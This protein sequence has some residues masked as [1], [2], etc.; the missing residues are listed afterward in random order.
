MSDDSLHILIV[1]DDGP[2]RA[3]TCQA[4]LL[5]RMS[6]AIDEAETAEDA[7]RALLS[8]DYDCALLE[9]QLPDGTGLD[10]MAQLQSEGIETPVVILSRH[11]DAMVAVELMKAGAADYQSKT[12]ITPEGLERAVKTAVRVRRAEQQAQT[13]DIARR[14]SE[15]QFRRVAES[16]I[17]GI[18]FWD[19]S[20]TVTDANDAFL[21]MVGYTRADL[22][23]GVIDWIALT[24]PEWQAQDRE[25]V[26]ELEA[27]GLCAPFEK[28]YI[29]KDGERVAVL[30]TTSMLEGS[31]DRG[32]AFVVDVTERRRT[33]KAQQFLAEA[34][35]ILSSSLNYAETLTNVASLAVPHLADWCVIDLRDNG[36]RV[37]Q[38][39]VAHVDPV[40]VE[41]LREMERRFPVDPQGG[42]GVP[43]V[44][45]T[46]RSLWVP[47]IT[48]DDLASVAQSEEHLESLRGYGLLSYMCVPLTA[49]GR[50]LGAITFLTSDSGR[51]YT[52]ADLALAEELA[53]R[54][55]LAVDNA[56]LF[57]E[58]Q[59]RAEREAVVNAIGQTLRGSL[60]ADEILE[61][62]TQEVGRLLK[63]SRCGWYWINAA[64]DALEVAPQQYV[65]GDV[66]S[67][68]GTFPLSLWEPH[69]LLHWQS[70]EA[71]ISND[72]EH[73]AHLAAYR[74]SFLDPLRI[75]AFVACPVF[76]RGVWKGLFMIQ[77]TDAPRVWTEDEVTLLRQVADMLAPTLENA[78]LYAREH[79]VADLLQAA[80]LSNV[81]THLNGLD[82]GTVYRPGLDESKVGGDFYDAF[83]TSDGRVGLVLG[84]VS[85]K[86]LSAAVLTATAKF[87][88]RAFA[89]EVAAPGLVLTRLNH[90][91]QSEMAGLGDHFVTLFYAVFDPAG[92]HL[93][94]ASAGHE[95]QIIKR[96]AG[97][98]SLLP[99]TGPILGIAEHR[100]EQH[101]ETLAPGDTLILYTDGLTEARSASTRELLDLSR[102][103]CLIDDLPAEVGAGAIA[104]YL[105]RIALD[106]TSERPQD[107]L[108]LLVARRR[109]P[110]ERDG[111]PTQAV[112][113]SIPLTLEGVPTSA[114]GEL[115]FQFA[116]PSRPD[117]AAEVRQ[118]VSHWMFTL[119]FR[120][121]EIDDFLTAT[122]EAVTN[123][124]R[125]GSPQGGADQFQ[126]S[127]YR[128][129]DVS[130]AVDVSDRGPGLLDAQIRAVMPGP[131]AIG[132]RGLPLM[133]QLSDSI[134][135]TS[136]PS[137]MRVRLIKRQTVES[138]QT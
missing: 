84:D 88:L 31:A 96:A 35:T 62:A 38:V 59:V 19:L 127:A 2:D 8:K 95:T 28:E 1:D 87:S 110:E 65:V 109:R 105:E 99:S 129:A 133:Q 123:A 17:I 4:L 91:L 25:R 80:F 85:G 135:Y 77:Q 3:A 132:G 7:V 92:G 9:S 79:R 137:G 70:G 43:E 82:L 49:R 27:L 11:G 26:L 100:F 124:I 81:P 34:G 13:A 125:H 50:V 68:S 6:L 24:P 102:V 56:R 89:A 98:T 74:D 115:L 47:E 83:V 58:A 39:A 108:A 41:A 66:E 36:G 112:A 33:E 45:Q 113:Q 15:G 78:R 22:D 90:T 61:V 119:G 21:E 86:G 23:A 20:G 63:V 48:D 118:A 122:S 71:V 5:S 103:V 60:D 51:R 16:N 94:Y 114:D 136:T 10:V 73:D 37:H 29:R 76:L 57:F 97:G 44:L 52:P 121:D 64:E 107:D 131:E 53:R 72:C 104:V 46:G 106:W 67:F 14:R 138:R 128:L 130:L 101:R 42:S 12:R 116:F 18:M 117:Y 54:A 40:Q 30:V 93:T 126:V 69:L 32:L 55:A 75:K 134:H 111:L 120:R